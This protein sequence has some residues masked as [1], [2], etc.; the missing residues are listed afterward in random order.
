LGFGLCFAACIDKKKPETV[1]KGEVGTAKVSAVQDLYNDIKE[2]KGTSLYK[3]RASR[4]ERERWRYADRR[5]ERWVESAMK[6]G[7]LD[8]DYSL[9]K[10]RRSAE[11]VEEE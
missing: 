8:S 3:D 11:V 10:P 5:R 6:S 1:L 2:E 9:K 7:Y 4:K